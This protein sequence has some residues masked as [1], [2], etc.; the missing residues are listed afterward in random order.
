[1]LTLN[2]SILK[3]FSQFRII[4]GRLVHSALEGF[5]LLDGGSLLWELESS[6][7]PIGVAPNSVGPWES[8]T[9]EKPT[10]KTQLMYSS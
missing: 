1:M 9:V 6:E 10:N 8:L 4:L 5:N 7:N 2:V 3:T